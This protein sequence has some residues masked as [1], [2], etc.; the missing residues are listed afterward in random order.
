VK[1]ESY[2]ADK[3][4]HIVDRQCTLKQTTCKHLQQDGRRFVPAQRLSHGRSMG[5]HACFVAR[6][7]GPHGR[8]LGL[9]ADGLEKGRE[10]M[11]NRDGVVS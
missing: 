1:K 8:L 11:S 10:V 9:V 5:A 3:G 2:A 4:V 7:A 6:S